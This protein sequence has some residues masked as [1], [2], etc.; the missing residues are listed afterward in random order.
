MRTIK[1]TIP[2]TLAFLMG[3]FGFFIHY[4]PGTWA[5]DTKGDIALWLRL[6]GGVA[7]VLGI[8]GLLNLHISKVRAKKEGWGY[9]LLFVV[10]FLVTVGAATYNAGRW[11][12]EPQAAR[13]LYQN[14][15][16]AIYDPAGATIFSLLGFFIASAAV[17]TFRARNLEATILLVAAV[18]VMI[19][20]VPM[21]E[22]LSPYFPRITDWIVA[23]PNMAAKRAILIG[24]S[25]GLIATSLR[26]VFGIERSYLGGGD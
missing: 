7:V 14:I 15:Y 6:I 11:L 19:G 9:S 24:I 10:T 20:R 16:N 3:L 4:C 17:R 26:V 21:G 13:S 2:L 5:A 1:L 23:V 12:T 25:L 18:I 8:Y 22:A